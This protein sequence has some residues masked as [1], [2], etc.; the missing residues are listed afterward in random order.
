MGGGHIKLYV[1]GS[2]QERHR[3]IYI[4][5]LGPSHV[6]QNIRSNIEVADRASRKPEEWF[7]CRCAGYFR[8]SL[9]VLDIN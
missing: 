3:R 5:M 8:M 1:V 4:V 6:A 2:I 7:Y 9:C